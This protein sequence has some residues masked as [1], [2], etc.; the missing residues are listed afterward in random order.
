MLSKRLCH[1]ITIAIHGVRG[2][3]TPARVLAASALLSRG[4][5]TQAQSPAWGGGQH[6]GQR[7]GREL[8]GHQL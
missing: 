3:L 2:L 8:V 5:P 1:S 6:Q 7:H 4:E